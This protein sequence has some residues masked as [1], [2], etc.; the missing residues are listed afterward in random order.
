MR[1]QV[2]SAEWQEGSVDFF[3]FDQTLDRLSFTVRTVGNQYAV[4]MYL[5]YF[6]NAEEAPGKE[7]V[8]ERIGVLGVKDNAD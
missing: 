5:G 8:A 6:F 4:S 3:L 2:Q 7:I 1:I